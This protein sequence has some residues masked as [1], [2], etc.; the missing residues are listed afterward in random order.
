M[1]PTLSL[2][3]PPYFVDGDTFNLD[4]VRNPNVTYPN[5]RKHGEVEVHL[6]GKNPTDVWL[7]Y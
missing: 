7:P 1:N 5:Q 2:D 4:A 3:P 6:L